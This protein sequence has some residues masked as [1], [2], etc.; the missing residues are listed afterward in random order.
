MFL[1]PRES[2]GP[3][4]LW[5]LVHLGLGPRGAVSWRGRGSGAWRG[6]QVTQ[7]DGGQLSL[8]R[9]A[10]PVGSLRPRVPSLWEEGQPFGRQ[11]AVPPQSPGDPACGSGRGMQMSTEAVL[12]A[13]EEFEAWVGFAQHSGFS[14]KR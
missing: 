3:C 14:K 5:A 12:C 4:P 13:G 1:G 11:G 6:S 7:R 9:G 8:A 2:H 10:G